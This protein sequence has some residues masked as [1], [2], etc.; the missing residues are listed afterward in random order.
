MDE[1]V[2]V[3][4]EPDEGGFSA[5]SESGC[6][7]TE[8]DTLEELR[9]NVCDAACCHCEEGAKPEVIKLRFVKTG[10]EETIRQ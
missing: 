9:R 7:F 8:A 5:R 10:R 3:V 6:I 1:L 4:E 2:F